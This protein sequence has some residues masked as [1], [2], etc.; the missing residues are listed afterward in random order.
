MTPAQFRAARS[1]LNINIRDMA[2]ECGL[3]VMTIVRFEAGVTVNANSLGIMEAAIARLGVT[4]IDADGV[5]GEG[6]RLAHCPETDQPST[7]L[8]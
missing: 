2:K 8:H 7:A 6:V 1:L 3:S 4:L 5:Q